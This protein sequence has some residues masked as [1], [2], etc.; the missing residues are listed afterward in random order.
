MVFSGYIRVEEIRGIGNHGL[1][2]KNNG[3]DGDYQTSVQLSNRS[4][5]DGIHR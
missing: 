4:M 5:G 2:G 3:T 1:S